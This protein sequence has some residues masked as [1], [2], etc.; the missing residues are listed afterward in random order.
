[1]CPHLRAIYEGALIYF[2]CSWN[3]KIAPRVESG[4]RQICES[5]SR[6]F[7]RFFPSH[8]STRLPTKPYF[9]FS[10]FE[11]RVW[12]LRLP[13]RLYIV[14]LSPTHSDITAARHGR[15]TSLQRHQMPRRV[16]GSGGG[17]HL[18]PHLLPQMRGQPWTHQSQRRPSHMPGMLRTARTPREG[19]ECRGVSSITDTDRHRMTPS[20]LH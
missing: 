8:S 18:Q 14:Q 7:S 17:D 12:F 13:S 3:E 19:D 6:T 16:L 9:H 20:A 5:H 10:I 2:V 1:M 4:V 11:S 15:H